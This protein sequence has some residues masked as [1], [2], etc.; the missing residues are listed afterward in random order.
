MTPA[1]RA[2]R[3]AFGTLPAGSF[4]E[5][6]LETRIE[7]Q[8]GQPCVS[9]GRPG[10]LIVE[11][12]PGPEVTA[13]LGLPPSEELMAWFAFC[14]RCSKRLSSDPELAAEFNRLAIEGFRKVKWEAESPPSAVYT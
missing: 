1:K 4:H 3:K 13:D 8:V 9:C 6:Y 11:W 12:K 14:N 5:A 2:A 7:D 10:T